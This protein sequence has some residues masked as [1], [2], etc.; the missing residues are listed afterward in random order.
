MAAS[1]SC[2]SD[3]PTPAVGSRMEVTCA[4][5]S[6]DSEKAEKSAAK[7]TVTINAAVFMVVETIAHTWSGMQ[8]NGVMRNEQNWA[9]ET[10]NGKDH[11]APIANVVVFSFG[12]GY[13]ARRNVRIDGNG[14]E[15]D[16]FGVLPTVQ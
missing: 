15:N 5:V 12:C 10:R 3:A 9:L 16:G 4:G 7:E 11:K 1:A 14:S 8:L 2:R 6:A 13:A